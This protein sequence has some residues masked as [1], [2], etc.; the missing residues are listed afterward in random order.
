MGRSHRAAD[1]TLVVAAA[2]P[3]HLTPRHQLAG[4]LGAAVSMAWSLPGSM[5][6]GVVIGKALFEWLS[7][8]FFQR[9]L[10][11]AADLERPSA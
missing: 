1:D 9:M 5:L 3:G 6:A 11:W 2:I 4:V 10:P 8:S 7:S